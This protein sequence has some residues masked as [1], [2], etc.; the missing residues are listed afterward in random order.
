MPTLSLADEAALYYELHGLD[1]H[2]TGTTPLLFLNGMTQTT[3][4]WKTLGR[5]M[6]STLPCIAYD[7]RGQGQSKPGT[8]PLTLD[9]HAKDLCELLDELDLEKVHLAGFSHGSRVALSFASRF[10]DRL[11]KLI[12]CSATAKPS[13]IARTIIRGWRE[14]LRHGGLEAMSWAAL[15]TIIGERYLG[16]HEHL[17]EGIIA[18]SVSRNQEDGVARLLEGMMS[19]PDLSELAQQVSADTLVISGEHDVLVDRAG[20]KELAR[21]CGGEHIEVEDVGHT[22]PIED[23]KTYQNLVL[24]FLNR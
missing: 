22:I 17:I 10:A 7:A 15:P 5:R 2:P 19:Y 20:A 12:L 11:D 4:S 16:Q 24:D 1:D 9:L 18:A 3:M 23:P 8:A 13:A 6:K 21:L 14:I